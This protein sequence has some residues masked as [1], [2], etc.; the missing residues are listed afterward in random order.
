MDN[1]TLKYKRLLLCDMAS[2]RFGRQYVSDNEQEVFPIDCVPSERGKKSWTRGVKA[3]EKQDGVDV[4]VGWFHPPR[5]RGKRTHYKKKRKSVHNLGLPPNKGD[6]YKP[7][8]KNPKKEWR[9]A[10]ADPSNRQLLMKAKK[11][12]VDFGQVSVEEIKNLYPAQ[13]Y[14]G[15]GSVP[16]G[17][18]DV[19]FPPLN[20]EEE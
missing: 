20:D 8:R 2:E 14:E 1:R 9:K 11:D 16:L 6:E 18:V 5:K 12:G 19:M 7:K 3:W 15:G 10:W 4:C 13:E 17:A